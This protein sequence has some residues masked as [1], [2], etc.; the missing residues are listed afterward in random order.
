MKTRFCLEIAYDEALTD[1]ER[2]AAAL[3]QWLAAAL[4]TPGQLEEHGR[5]V[6]RPVTVADAAPA[7]ASRFVL[8]NYDQECLATTEVFQQYE[9]AAELAQRCHN[10]LVIP[11]VIP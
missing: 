7:V 3:D 5:L 11:L 6:C 10:V 9:A 4:A 2:L 8:L 1:P